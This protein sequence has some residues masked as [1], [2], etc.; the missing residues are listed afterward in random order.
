MV[1]V[2]PCLLCRLNIHIDGSKDFFILQTAFFSFF[3]MESLLRR[4]ECSSAISIHHNLCLP[5]S[6]YSPASAS[7]VPGTTGM[8]RHA[9]LNYCYYYFFVFLVQ[10][11]IHYVDQTGLERL[12]S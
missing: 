10:T 6:S 9:R 5:G 12:T 3:E 11:G 4:L 1:Y 2:S 8:H 7:R